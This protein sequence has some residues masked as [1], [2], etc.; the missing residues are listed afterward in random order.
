MPLFHRKSPIVVVGVV[1]LIVVSLSFCIAPIATHV[2]FNRAGIAMDKQLR[3][4]RPT[5]PDAVDPII[6][7]HAHSWI[8]TAHCNVCFSAEHTSVDEMYRLQADLD[9]KLAEEVDLDTLRWIWD[10]LGATGPHGKQYTERFG[11]LFRDTIRPRR[12][13]EK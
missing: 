3:D 13:I 10:R 4:L 9:G 5:H 1:T 12:V 6:W 11:Q 2:E 7:K 8:M